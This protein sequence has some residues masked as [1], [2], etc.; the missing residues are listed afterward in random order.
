MLK[1]DRSIMSSNDWATTESPWMKSIG[2][3]V[4]AWTTDTIMHP[5]LNFRKVCVQWV[6]CQTTAEQH[7]T[8]LTLS[9]N[10]LQRYREE[11]YDFLSQI[12]TGSVK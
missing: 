2:Y 7:N 10:H 5:Y 12:F 3:W 4:L 9:F 11:K 1:I 6:P 8:R